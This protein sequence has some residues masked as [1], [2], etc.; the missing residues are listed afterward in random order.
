MSKIDSAEKSHIVWRNIYILFVVLYAFG[1]V[2]NASM[3]VNGDEL[4]FY[5]A[6]KQ[7]EQVWHGLSFS[8]SRFFPLAGWNLNL[9]AL[10]STS[11]YAFMIGNMCVF[12]ITAWAFWRIAISLGAVAKWITLAGIVFF[13]S[14]GYAHIVISIC[15]PELTQIMFLLLFVLMVFWYFE[16]KKFVWLAFALIFGNAC[17]YMKEVAF[18][19]VG[20]FG[21]FHLFFTLQNE[22]FKFKMLEKKIVLFDILCMLS[23]MLFLGLYYVFASS[24]SDYRNLIPFSITHTIFVS[25]FGTPFLSILLC[26]MLLFRFYRILK[27]KEKIIPMADSIGMIALGYWAGYIVLG[28][29]G[30]HYFSPANILAFLY[31]LFCAHLYARELN[32][33]FARVVL[34]VSVCILLSSGVLQGLNALT[35]KTQGKNTQDAFRFLAEYI[36]TSPEKVNL[37]FDGFCRGQDRCIN[38]GFYQNAVFTMLQNYVQTD[39]YDIKSKEPNGNNFTINPNSPLTFFNSDEVSEPQSGDIVILHYMSSKYMTPSDVQDIV[40]QY[41]TLFVSNNYPYYPMYNLMSLGAWALKK[42]GI[43]TSF[44]NRGNIFKLPSQVYVLRVP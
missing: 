33:L 7:G 23:A 17:I 42:L 32:F 2:Y 41:E 21:F 3:L 43:S 35:S 29:G 38:A 5:A 36:H 40:A 13:L 18:I 26:F 19:L 24:G 31:A 4:V 34:Y 25:I 39:N 16:S 8:L 20:G 37:Y 27:Y 22:D 30:F 10:F 11:P 6:F 9:V 1:I 12:I 15:Y 44:D 14:A 28:M